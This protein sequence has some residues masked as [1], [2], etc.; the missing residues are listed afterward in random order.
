MIKIEM[1]RVFVEV[2]RAG[3]LV[4]AAERLGRVPSALSTSLK[5]LEEHLGA[6]LFESERKSHLTPLGS[7]TLEV[8]S[9]EVAQLERSIASLMAF[10]QGQT[11]EVR[12]A[13]VPSFATAVLPA[14][15]KAF[16]AS[17]P[18]VRL[19]IYDM[20][21]AAIRSALRE[22]R[23]DAGILSD[24]TPDAEIDLF[25]LACDPFG[26]VMRKDH[27]LAAQKSV[28]FAELA[29]TDVI[30][31]PLCRYLPE[32]PKQEIERRARLHIQNTTALL[33]MVR[34]GLGVTLLPRLVASQWSKSIVFLPLADDLPVR[35]LDLLVRAGA[36][37]SPATAAFA[38]FLR[39]E[40]LAASRGLLD[41]LCAR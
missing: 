2:A 30:V 24:G 4:V 34:A 33:A 8:A 26:I 11:G 21:S 31:N 10:A 23:I 18:G 22:E 15:V 40:T 35:Q 7:F 25:T 17:R 19:E 29:D 5:Q 6:P 39:S 20:D 9:R 32:E 37:S 3:S 16:L 13:A 38:A 36:R 27:P 1:L 28:S 14:L 41:P 12:L